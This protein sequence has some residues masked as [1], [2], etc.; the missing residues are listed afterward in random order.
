MAL[1]R[2]GDQD[3]GEAV[4]GPP[5]KAQGVA[6]IETHRLAAA[7]DGD[8]QGRRRVLGERAHALG[9]DV[10]HPGVV[11]GRADVLQRLAVGVHR[12]VDVARLEAH[13]VQPVLAQ[14]GMEPAGRLA[15]QVQEGVPA[16][17]RGGDELHLGG[18][19]KG[20]AAHRQRV[21]GLRDDLGRE[22]R[23]EQQHAARVAL[24]VERI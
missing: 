2:L 23:D 19:E 22:P 18:H 3:V 11:L 15:Q 7:G 20:L 8:V 13:P 12:H 14:E 10:G 1:V 21:E 4:L 5:V 24:R 17:P 6:G 16:P 9:D